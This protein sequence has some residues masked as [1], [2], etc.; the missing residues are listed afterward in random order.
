MN[1]PS[2]PSLLSGLACLGAVCLAAGCAPERAELVYADMGRTATATVEIPESADEVY[3]AGVAVGR[4][5]HLLV[6]QKADGTART[7]WM[8][9]GSQDAVLKAVAVAPERSRLI[10]DVNSGAGS[11]AD[12]R[13]ALRTAGRVCTA[14]GVTYAVNE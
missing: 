3:A 12:K 13:L 6:I 1:P 7:I 11:A 5:D 9:Q 2:F 4:A 10:V 14:L 8:R